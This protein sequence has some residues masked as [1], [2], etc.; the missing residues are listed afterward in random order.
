VVKCGAPPEILGLS[1]AVSRGAFTAPTLA[2]VD[3]TMGSKG[4]GG[5][6]E[7]VGPVALRLGGSVLLWRERR[8]LRHYV[9]F[10]TKYQASQNIPKVRRWTDSSFLSIH[11]IASCV[12]FTIETQNRLLLNSRINQAAPGKLPGDDTL[13][14]TA[15]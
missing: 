15:T 10:I 8:T 12:P 4:L 11:S 2:G 14:C 13:G 6:S 5:T 1:S 3:W 9:I 7:S